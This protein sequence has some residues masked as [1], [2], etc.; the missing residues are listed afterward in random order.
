MQTYLWCVA[1]DRRIDADIIQKILCG[2][3]LKWLPPAFSPML[4]IP[5]LFWSAWNKFWKHLPWY[6]ERLG[7][8]KISERMIPI[9][10]RYYNSGMPSPRSGL[11]III[12]WRD[13][14]G[15]TG[16]LPMDTPKLNSTLIVILIR[17]TTPMISLNC[18]KTSHVGRGMVDHSAAKNLGIVGSSIGEAHGDVQISRDSDG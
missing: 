8:L 14:L 12:C 18:Q 2:N 7:H 3:I 6:H 4:C 17:K 16:A 5:R 10:F 1:G 13:L 11:P 15:N 9:P